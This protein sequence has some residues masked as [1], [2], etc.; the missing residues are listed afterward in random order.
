MDRSGTADDDVLKCR[1]DPREQRTIE[2]ADVERLLVTADQ[3]DVLDKRRQWYTGS[4]TSHA[5]TR[6]AESTVV[7][8]KSVTHLLQVQSTSDRDPIPTSPARGFEVYDQ[9]K[10]F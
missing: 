5:R 4:C 7:Q 9:E 8:R 3:I 1:D 6:T 2:Y 10:P